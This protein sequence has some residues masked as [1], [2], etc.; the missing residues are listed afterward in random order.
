MEKEKRKGD[1]PFPANLKEALNDAQWQA[2]PGITLSGWE[3]RY[4]RRLLF[5]EP[6]LVIYTTGGNRTGILGSDER[7]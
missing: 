7:I 2:L 4:L 1:A 6:E 3:L 5:Q